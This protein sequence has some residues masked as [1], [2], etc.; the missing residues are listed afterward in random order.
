MGK[1]AGVL[2]DIADPA[3]VD[4][5]IEAPVTV[6]YG[7]AIDGDAPAI[8]PGETRDTSMA[9][10]FPAPDRPN[11]AVTLPAAAPK[12]AFKVKAPRAFWM[13]TSIMGYTGLAGRGG[14]PRGG[15]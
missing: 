4:R 8:R 1:Q 12:R 9:V 14:A 5:S 11:R 13:S 6:E 15:P 2:K 10:V 7:R 3:R